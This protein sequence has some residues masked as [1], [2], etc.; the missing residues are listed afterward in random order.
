MEISNLELINSKVVSY[1]A[2]LLPVVKNRTNEE[3][4]FLYE[5]GFREF[6]ENRLTDF[7]L[8]KTVYKDVD[9]HFI[10]PIQSRKLK[11]IV[12]NFKYLHTISRKKEIDILNY[13]EAM[14]FLK[15]DDILGPYI[16]S[17]S[18]PKFSIF[19]FLVSS[20]ETGISNTTPESGHIG[21]NG[22]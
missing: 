11:E 15:N 20:S 9:Y 13:K 7:N 1:G 10:A 8:H 14:L 12:K 19:E 4:K 5:F 16:K 6:G 3:I 17:I 21:K 18:A 2:R 22:E